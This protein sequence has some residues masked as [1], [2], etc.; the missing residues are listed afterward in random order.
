MREQLAR[1][2]EAGAQLALFPELAVTGYPPE[3]LLLK[4]HFLAD[5]RAA[6]ERIAA[7]AQGIVALVGF[8]ERADDAYNAAA[9]LA[10]GGRAGHLPQGQPAQLRG[11]RRAALLPARPRRGDHRGRRRQ[12]RPHHLRGH[13]GPRSADDRRGAGRRAAGAQHLRLALPGR[14]GPPARADDR[15][16]RARQPRRGRLLRARRRPGRARLRRPLVRRRPR[17]QRDRPRAAVRRGAPGVR[18]RRRRPP[19]PRACATRARG[20][21]R[22]RW[23]RWWPTS[24]RSR[25]R[26]APTRRRRAARSPSCSTPTPRSTRRSSSAR[27]TT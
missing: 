14:Q 20:R 15:P 5:A 23:R 9:V 11:L 16:A 1:A 22:A 4:E 12:G 2:R 7:D 17:R 19:A 18:H 10:D 3:D 13:L 8:P 25:P 27:A 6:V 24:G 21:R 26:A